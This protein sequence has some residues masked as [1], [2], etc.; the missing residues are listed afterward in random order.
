MPQCVFA[1]CV[2]VDVRLCVWFVHMYVN[3]NSLLL[4]LH[5]MQEATAKQGFL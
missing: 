5:K 1:C 3:L 4:A 2:P